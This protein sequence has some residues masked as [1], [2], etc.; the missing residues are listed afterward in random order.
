VRRWVE[1]ALH[2]RHFVERPVDN[3]GLLAFRTLFGALMVFATLRFMA[4]GWVDELLVDPPFH[5][6]YF[7]FEWVKPWPRVWMF[8]HYWLMALSALLLALGVFARAAAFSFFLLFTYA[9]LIDKATYLNHYYLVSLLSFLLCFIPL[10]SH[11]SAKIAQGWYLLLRCQMALVY[12]FAGFAKLNA[13]WLFAAEPLSTWLRA[14]AHLPWVGPLLAQPQTA[15]V[16]SWA[17]AAFDLTIPFLLAARATR[18]YAFALAL[19][20]HTVVWLLFPIG[21]FSFV[22]LVAL[23]VFFEPS[24]PRR[25]LAARGGHPNPATT[26]SAITAAPPQGRSVQQ[27]RT[28]LLLGAAVYLLAQVLIPLRFTLYPGV[29]NWTEQ[30]FRFAWRVML[31]EKAGQV[32]F[33]VKSATPDARF[34]VNPRTELTALQYRQMATQP[35]MIWEYAHHLRRRFEAEGYQQ[36]EVFA[37]AWVAFNRR[38][39]QRL[40]DPEVNLAGIARSLKAQGWVLPLAP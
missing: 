34:V 18:R 19:V 30:G 6:T 37:D 21:V 2:F 5:F 23:S 9:E 39:S 26:E 40:I 15:Y 8:A 4:N 14:R 36:V 22:M 32:E 38:P 17:G 12:L 16:M 27:R 10:G 25:A 31:V 29:V 3:A 24:W 35:D 1:G 28:L 7:G 20:F 11:A 13:D 33:R